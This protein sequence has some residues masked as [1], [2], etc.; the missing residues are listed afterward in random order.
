MPKIALKNMAGERVGDLDLNDNIFA[1]ELNVPLMHQA[2]VTENA[3]ARQGNADTK[4]RDEISGGGA[5]PFRQKGTGRARQG[6]NRAPQYY[7][8]GI[9]FGPTPRSYQKAMPKKMRRAAVKS[10]LS[11]RLTD[12]DIVILDEIKMESIS[13]KKMAAVLSSLDV[14]GRTLMVMESISNE[15]MKS[16]RNIPGVEMRISPA[17]GVRDI[18]NADKIVMTR[19]A[20][21]KLEEILAS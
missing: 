14:A 6:D 17:I 16:A 20:V 8:G 15:V 11:A 1:V 21:E 18:L 12:E 9:V 19:G 5:K 7:H 10:A 4:G 13:T 2:V 3:N